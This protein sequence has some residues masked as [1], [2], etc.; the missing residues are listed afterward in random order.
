MLKAVILAA[1]KGTRMESELP[2]VLHQVLGRPMVSYVIDA[3]RQAGAEQICLVVGHQAELVRE[4]VGDGVKYVLQ[5]QQLGTGHAVIC[6]RDFIGDEGDVLILCGDTPLIQGSTLKKMVDVHCTSGNGATVLSTVLEDAAG[7][8]RIVR[9]EDG[10]FI[11]NVEQKDA[12]PEEQEV[13]EV[14]SG[15][16]IFRAEALQE[17]L[18]SLTNDNAQGEYYLPDVLSFI[19]CQGRLKVDAMVTDQR[20][21]IRGVNTKQQLYEAEEIM[22]RR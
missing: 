21:D 10:A 1:G 22:K 2:K 15:M 12:S 20:D 4:T 14:N 16:Y 11:K 19:N 13:K 7:Y 8:G 5:E 9:N 17:G 3:A 6:A 18:D